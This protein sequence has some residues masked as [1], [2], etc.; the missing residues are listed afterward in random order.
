[1]MLII[2]NYDSFVY[3]L[4]QM[5]GRYVTDIRVVRN[6]VIS[7]A[8]ID[9]MSPEQIVL[10]PG[11]GW[12]S[13]AG[14]C[15]SVIENFAGKIPLLGVCLGHQALCEVAGAKI[16]HSKVKM[17]GKS[18]IMMYDVFAPYHPLFDGVGENGETKVARYHSLAVDA[19]TLPDDLHVLAKSD[20]GEVMAVEYLK[21][22][23]PAIGVQFHPESILTQ[24]G[25][26]MLK[27]FVE[28]S[29]NVV[30]KG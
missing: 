26:Q 1:M 14:L 30:H 17:H 24:D 19:K 23:A 22:D 16:V 28:T 18:S 13:D 15:K 25:D 29:A 9:Q 20:D 2:D 10:S 7:I 27:N 3:N 5:L 6:D 12:P 21:G 11:P 8:D 4:Y